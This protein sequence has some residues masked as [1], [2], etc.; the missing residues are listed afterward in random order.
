MKISQLYRKFLTV[1]WQYKSLRAGF[2]DTMILLCT[3]VF[4]LLTVSLAEAKDYTIAWSPSPEPVEGYKFYYKRG[5]NAGP[6]F[7]GTES[8]KGPSPIP[9]GKKTIFTITGLADNTPYHFALK[10]YSGSEE[11]EFSP[12][13]SVFTNLLELAAIIKPLNQLGQAPFTVVF[14][15]GQSTGPISTY[16]WNFGDGGSG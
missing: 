3:L 5:G 1:N 10:A 15:A 12:V 7:D 16:S 6:P 9:A 8:L 4:Y 11:S 2:L 13:V 14:D